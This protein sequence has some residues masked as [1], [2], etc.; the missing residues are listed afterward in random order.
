MRRTDRVPDVIAAELIRGRGLVTAARCGAIGVS[1]DRVRTLQRGGHLVALA[2]GVYGD[3][4]S[5]GELSEWDRFR[6]ASRAFLASSPP[7]CIAA[8]W[9]AIALLGLPTPPTAPPV[10]SVLRRISKPGSGSNRT[11]HGRTRYIPVPDRWTWRIDGL[12]VVHPAVAAVDL[13]RTVGAPWSLILIDAAGARSGGD[14]AVRAAYASMERWWAIGRA[15]WAVDNVDS[16]SDSPLESAGR[17][18]LLRAGLPTPVSNVWL[19]THRPMV[20]V[21]H[22]WPEQRVAGEADGIGKYG[23][24]SEPLKVLRAE[25]DREILLAR[26]GVRVFRYGWGQAFS[27]DSWLA[28]H[29]RSVLETYP[30]PRLDSLRTWPYEVGCRLLGIP[31]RSPGSAGVEPLEFALS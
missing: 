18:A 28:S 30:L 23:E 11:P 19:G 31:Y 27:E 16:D 26:W 5:V 13:A 7:G 3:G 10:P 24:R 21:D 22:Y 6:L 20:R 14:A 9:S 25:K 1:K 2:K 8:D 12:H 15:R 29:A 4:R 17:S